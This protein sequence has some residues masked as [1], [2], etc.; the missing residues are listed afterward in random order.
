MNHRGLGGLGEL[1]ESAM[2]ADIAVTR[3]VHENAMRSRSE[4]RQLFLCQ[5]PRVVSVRERPLGEEYG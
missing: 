5:S 1:R 3:V 4:Q 2:T